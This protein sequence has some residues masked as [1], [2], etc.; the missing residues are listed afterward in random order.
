MVAQS[1]PHKR[2]SPFPLFV[3]VIPRV[4]RGHAFPSTR[5]NTEEIIGSAPDRFFYS[6]MV[7]LVK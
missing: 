2:V 1:A 7:I 3:G 4:G 5:M 6:G